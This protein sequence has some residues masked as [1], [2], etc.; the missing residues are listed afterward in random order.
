MQILN[1]LLRIANSCQNVQGYK[2][3]SS[4]LNRIFDQLPTI[5]EDVLSFLTVIDPDAE[6]KIDFL[7]SEEKWP[8]IPQ[9]K[10]ASMHSYPSRH[11]LDNNLEKFQDIANV[12]RELKDYLL[13]ERK[14]TG[15]TNLEFVHV[16]GIEVIKQK[17]IRQ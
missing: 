9:H 16:A 8:E 2:F 17:R 7:R 3:R 13:T 6:S 4:L 5:R 1:A 14:Q 11:V 15:I 12:E 10:Q